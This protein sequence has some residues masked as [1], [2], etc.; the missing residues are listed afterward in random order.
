MHHP[1]KLSALACCVFLSVLGGCKRSEPVAPAAAA[2]VSII[3]APRELTA[4]QAQ[5]VVTENTPITFVGGSPGGATAQYLAEVMKQTTGVNLRT[6]ASAAA[7]AE[8]VIRFELTA[9]ESRD[10][11]EGYSLTISPERIVVSAADSR[12]LFYGAVTLWQLMTA[13]APTPT[14]PR[15]AGEGA[16]ASITLPALTIHDA[17][18]F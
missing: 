3:P 13:E 7:D 14:L 12:G 2:Y 11:Q 8:G 1:Y 9:R 10:G 4:S 16:E 6:E 18:R 15:G 5:F 17:P